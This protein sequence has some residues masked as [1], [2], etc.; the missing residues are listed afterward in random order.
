[1]GESGSLTGAKKTEYMSHKHPG[2]DHEVWTGGGGMSLP[3]EIQE[4]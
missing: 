2:S 1:M 4:G 3:S